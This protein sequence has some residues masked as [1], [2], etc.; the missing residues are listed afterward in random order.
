MGRHVPI[1][2]PGRTISITIPIVSDVL[3]GEWGVFAIHQSKFKS[4]TV[5]LIKSEKKGMTYQVTNTS[6]LLQ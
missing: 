4:V 2:S 1:A 6:L 5:F 3:R